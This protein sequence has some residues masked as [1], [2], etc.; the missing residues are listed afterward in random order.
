[1]ATVMVDRDEVFKKVRQ[2][3]VDAL[4]V[5]E[6]EVTEDASLTADL[7]AESIDILDVVFRLEKAFGIKISQEELAPRDVLSNPEFVVNGKLNAAGLE[8]LKQRVPYADFSAFEKDPDISKVF[9]AFTV[10]TIVKFVQHKL[11]G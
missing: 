7:G 10:G 11:A 9:D 6:D 8:A 2:S 3:L 4:S 5:D 1:M